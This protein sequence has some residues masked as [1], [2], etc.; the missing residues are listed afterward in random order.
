MRVLRRLFWLALAVA[1]LG[2]LIRSGV[3]Q[4]VEERENRE[5]LLGVQQALQDFHVDQERYVPRQRL[6][7]HQLLGVLADLGHLD[8][9][10]ANP[11][12][13]DTWKLD[14]EEPD[15]LVYETD[16]AFETYSLIIM[17]STGKEVVM[18]LDSE[19]NPSL[20]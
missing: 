8:E 16:P 7:G 3:V 11:W 1:G 2:W 19:S 14:G 15:R 6:S 9:L 17:D 10:P 13:G 12:T 18:E 20:E 4:V 5:F